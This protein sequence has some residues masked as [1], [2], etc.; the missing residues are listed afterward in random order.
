MVFIVFS[1][2]VDDGEDADMNKVYIY[3][4]IVGVITGIIFLLIECCMVY[5]LGFLLTFCLVV[6]ILIALFVGLFGMGST[7][8]TISVLVAFV[9]GIFGA[10]YA[11]KVRDFIVIT[12]TALGGGQMIMNGF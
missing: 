3:T 10:C 5:L 12:L 1:D 8:A 9:A 6:T 7:G 11:P 4:F 2:A